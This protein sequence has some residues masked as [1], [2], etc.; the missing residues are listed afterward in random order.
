MLPFG[1]I[2]Q[3]DRHRPVALWAAGAPALSSPPGLTGGS[4]FF[5]Y[6]TLRYEKTMWIPRSHAN[7]CIR[8]T[9]GMT[10]AVSE[11]RGERCEATR[12]MT[13]DHLIAGTTSLESAP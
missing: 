3:K 4:K 8:T 5:F 7:A 12:G 13:D 1:T 2:T 6:T 11:C 9:R 10:E